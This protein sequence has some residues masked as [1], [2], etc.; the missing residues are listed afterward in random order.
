[1][2]KL[3]FTIGCFDVFHKGHAN[4][5]NKMDDMAQSVHVLLHDDY[6]IFQNK[7]HFPAKSFNDRY[8]NLE[9]YL[10][11]NIVPYDIHPVNRKDPKS[12]VKRM[13]EPLSYEPDQMVFVRGDDWK[14][15]PARDYIEEL[16]IDIKFVEYTDGISSTNI[17]KKY[18]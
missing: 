1:M 8:A 5:L 14:D 6:S 4:L 15:F 16:G 9:E 12:A 17:R 11:N 2:K 7:G 3:A 18:E 13:I 10:M